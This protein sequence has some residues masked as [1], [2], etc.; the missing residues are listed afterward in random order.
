MYSRPRR[1]NKNVLC[2]RFFLLISHWNTMA[3]ALLARTHVILVFFQSRNVFFCFMD[4]SYVITHPIFSFPIPA[5]PYYS[6]S[7]LCTEIYQCSS[8]QYKT[9]RMESKLSLIQIMF[10]LLLKC[11]MQLYTSCTKNNAQATCN[12]LS[13]TSKGGRTKSAI[14]YEEKKSLIWWIFIGVPEL[15]Y[16]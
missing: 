4:R 6:L 14:A 2:V 15:N 16:R 11:V 8:N 12:W 10:I 5:L 3:F 9:A 7:P 1:S 13:E